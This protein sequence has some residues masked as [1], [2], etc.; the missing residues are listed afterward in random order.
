MRKRDGGYALIYVVVVILLLCALVTIVC[1][2]SLRN[3]KAQY[4]SLERTQ[5]LYM[6]EGLAEQFAGQVQS[7]RAEAVDNC[8]YNTVPEAF[9]AAKTAA[10]TAFQGWLNELNLSTMEQ[11]AEEWETAAESGSAG[12]YTKVIETDV[13]TVGGSIQ[14]Q[15]QV[16]IVFQVEV[17]LEEHTYD[18]LNTEGNVVDTVLTYSYS[19]TAFV[20]SMEYQTYETSAAGESAEGEDAR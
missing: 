10:D 17:D 14:L 8:E 1:S 11:T 18:V 3:M 12:A 9:H 6:A 13:K 16:Q 15:A 5:D 20:A 7:Y 19:Y 4:A 2:V